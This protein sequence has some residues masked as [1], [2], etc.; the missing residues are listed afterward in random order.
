MWLREN[1]VAESQTKGLFIPVKYSNDIWDKMLANL[2]TVFL[3]V[4]WQILLSKSTSD[5]SLKIETA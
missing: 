1:D 2:E 4:L 5:P 3:W